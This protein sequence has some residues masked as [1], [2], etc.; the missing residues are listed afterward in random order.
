VQVN[1]TGD[2][3]ATLDG[4]F[5]FVRRFVVLDEN[6]LVAVALWVF[7]T[8]AFEAADTTPYLNVGSAEKRS[9]KTRFLET[10]EL[11][12]AGP[13]KVSGTTPAA[14][15]RVV[16]QEPPPTL[17][18]DEA[19]NSLRRD[20]EYVAA[21]MGVL[22]DGYRRGG[23][24]LLC[25]PPKWEPGF[26]PVF[27][28]KAIAGIGELPDTVAD[29]SISIRLQRRTR[30]ERIE[31]FRRREVEASADPIRESMVSLA[32]FHL[33][34]LTDAR[35]ELPDELDDRAQDV[36]EPL[37]AIA[38]LA[39]AAW[40]DRARRAAIALSSG[41]ER[42]DDSLSARLLRDI[43]DVYA[44]NGTQRYRTA[45]LIAELS[46]IEESPWGDWRGKPIT[47]QELSRLLRPHKIKTMPVWV[48]GQTVKG[49]KAEQFENAWLRVLGVRWVRKVRSGSSIEAGPNPP[50]LP[51][52]RNG[53][54]DDLNARDDLGASEPDTGGMT[55]TSILP[56]FPDTYGM[57]SEEAI[58]ADLDYLASEHTTRHTSEGTGLTAAELQLLGTRPLSEI[59]LKFQ[60]ADS[61][62]RD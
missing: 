29:R 35:P 13:V 27:A 48:N 4:V 51:N 43:Y 42:E 61:E 55:E 19:D 56:V 15:A 33:V 10:V 9:G 24:T 17:L 5:A 41:T 39:G 50:N 54:A 22:N 23:K 38:D 49:Y 16:A 37:L 25:L 44:A 18:I 36:W 32:E 59:A 46:Q 26:L 11:L 8:H 34:R 31:R 14:L 2:L 52:P 20:R 40:P 53:E 58:L 57:T 1:T 7:H 47:S 6:Q 28:P 45:D 21:L 12:V 62:P 3:A 60:H 30:D